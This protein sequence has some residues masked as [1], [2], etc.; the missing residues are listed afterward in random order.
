MAHSHLFGST[1]ADLKAAIA[2]SQRD[3][4][5]E[6][7]A[8]DDVAAAVA[9]SKEE[10]EFDLIL[11]IFSSVF[12]QPKLLELIDKHC[13][14]FDGTND[15]KLECTQIHNDYRQMLDEMLTTAFADLK[16]TPAQFELFCTQC[17]KFDRDVPRFIKDWLLSAD[18]YKLFKQMMIDRRRELPHTGFDRRCG[19]LFHKGCSA[20]QTGENIAQAGSSFK[21]S[22][23][24]SGDELAVVTSAAHAETQGSQSTLA[25]PNGDPEARPGTP[26]KTPQASPR[27]ECNVDMM[28][29][30]TSDETPTLKNSRQFLLYNKLNKADGPLLPLQQADFAVRPEPWLMGKR[31]AA[32]ALCSEPDVLAPEKGSVPTEEELQQ[33]AEYWRRQREILRKSR[34]VGSTIQSDR[35]SHP[36]SEKCNNVELASALKCSV[37]GQPK[38]ENIP[39]ANVTAARSAITRQL[40]ATF[41]GLKD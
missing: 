2:L 8:I 23:A 39:P 21:E 19:S 28:V 36:Q 31:T 29:S 20:A 26:L 41:E 16:L 18:E 32:T 4:G 13:I 15:N 3:E 9:L 40:R 35:G 5:L 14:S 1:A 30:T 38:R 10:E 11:D 22:K 24:I 12:R 34:V 7:F 33:R 6:A 17:L 27:Q 37:D 25:I